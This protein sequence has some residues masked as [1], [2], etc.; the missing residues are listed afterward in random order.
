MCVRASVLL[1]SGWW[2]ADVSPE[3]C[4]PC[5]HTWLWALTALWSQTHTHTYS[6]MCSTIYTITIHTHTLY[7][8]VASLEASQNSRRMWHWCPCQLSLQSP[9]LWVHVS[10]HCTL[11]LRSTAN[12]NKGTP[13]TFIF[14]LL[15]GFFA[16]GKPKKYMFD[17]YNTH[18]LS[19]RQNP[20]M[21]TRGTMLDVLSTL[22]TSPSASVEGTYLIHPVT[23]WLQRTRG[24]MP[25]CLHFPFSSRV[26]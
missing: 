5:S 18:S 1:I 8:L 23:T 3:H 25:S 24:G 4:T 9:V 22:C 17:I 19:V 15:L 21:V 20:C 13:K 7:T 10:D 16:L 11:K 26:G 2:N 14:L 12:P 6:N